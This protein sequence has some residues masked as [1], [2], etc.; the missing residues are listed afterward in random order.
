MIAALLGADQT[1]ARANEPNLLRFEAIIASSS[2]Y[3]KHFMRNFLDS[4][5]IKLIG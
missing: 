1:R 3:F 5:K 4:R 2:I